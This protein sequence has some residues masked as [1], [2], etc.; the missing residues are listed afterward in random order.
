MRK[1]QG[2][3]GEQERVD[4]SSEEAANIAAAGESGIALAAELLRAGALV[5]MPTETVYGLA[6]DAGNA[7]AVARIFEVKGR[8]RFNPLICH[9]TG[10]TAAAELAVIPP[11]AERLMAAFWPGPL[12]LVLERREG[13]PVAELV[14]AG[15][16][17]IALRAPA[18]TAARQLLFA[19]D[20]PLAAPSANRSG[21]VSPTTA[22]HVA[23]DLDGDVDLILDGGRCGVG[24]ESTI[25]GVEGDSL[26]LL[27]LGAVTAEDIRDATGVTPAFDSGGGI[28]APGQLARHYAP[29]TRLRLN[30][31]KR[32]PGEVLIGFGPVCGDFSLSPRGDLV[33]AAARLFAVLRG[34]DAAGAEAIAVAPIPEQGLGLAINDRLRR[35]ASA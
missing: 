4:G 1:R 10:S 26:A 19:V 25:L 17:T 35:A 27:R 24:L 11:L 20:R 5:A 28:N 30:A 29:A 31:T 18:H 14:S 13:A 9:V 23:A 6:A 7:E 21:R 12:T 15:L 33:E 2:K 34:A 8:P 32:R 22:A 16:P 3:D